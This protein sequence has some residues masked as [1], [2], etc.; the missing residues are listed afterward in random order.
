M[1]AWETICSTPLSLSTLPERGRMV[2]EFHQ[3]ELRE[4]V[5]RSYRII[6]RVN[7]ASRSVEIVRFWHSA[8]GF[9]QIPRTI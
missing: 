4:V 3:I 9:P 7:M 5:F 8:R 1:S 6:Y 2:P